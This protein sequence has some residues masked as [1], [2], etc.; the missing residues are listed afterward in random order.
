MPQ[1]PRRRDNDGAA[2]RR[3]GERAHLFAGHGRVDID[4]GAGGGQQFSLPRC[5]LRSTGDQGALVLKCK[6]RR[7]PG[8]STHA[9]CPGSD[10]QAAHAGVLAMPLEIE[11]LPSQRN[12]WRSIRNNPVEENEFTVNPFKLLRA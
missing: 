11:F 8:Q 1:P 5:G 3:T 2:R 4:Q 12:R 6:E 10:R 7:Q 9:S